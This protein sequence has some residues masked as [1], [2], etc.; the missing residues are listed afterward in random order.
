MAL[1]ASGA[2]GKDVIASDT[3]KRFEFAVDPDIDVLSGV[4]ADEM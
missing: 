1:A 2:A 3:Q 4:G